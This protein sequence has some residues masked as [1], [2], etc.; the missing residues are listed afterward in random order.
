MIRVVVED[1]V[2]EVLRRA[3]NLQ[4]G[5]KAHGPIGGRTPM[6][7]QNAWYCLVF[8][9]TQGFEANCDEL[10]SHPGSMDPLTISPNI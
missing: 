4:G 5:G 8:K 1:F 7:T 3:G 2:Y 9:G 10:C 6:P